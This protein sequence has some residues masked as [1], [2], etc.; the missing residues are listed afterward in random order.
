MSLHALS[1]PH[2]WERSSAWSLGRGGRGGAAPAPTGLGCGTDVPASDR[3]PVIA[4]AHTRAQTDCS[5]A[6]P[7]SGRDRAS[8]TCRAA[9][10]VAAWPTVRPFAAAWPLNLNHHF[11]PPPAQ[12]PQPAPAPP[13]Q[14][15]RRCVRPRARGW[16]WRTAPGD[17]AGRKAI[18]W[19][20][21]GRPAGCTTAGKIF[22][23]IA[24]GFRLFNGFPLN[25][26]LK[27][28]RDRG[29]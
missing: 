23:L 17:G 27:T 6:H 11:R 7:R 28:I 2:A 20:H 29:G 13:R 21:H 10:R 19:L 26:R 25:S 5:A 16:R 3:G 4:R 9:P 14:Q 15:V 8:P 1:M 12:R 22:V 18:L 24:H